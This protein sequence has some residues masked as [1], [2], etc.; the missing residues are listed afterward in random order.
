M[1]AVVFVAAFPKPS[2]SV[3][4]N[5]FVAWEFA[6]PANGVELIA[7]CVPVPAVMVSCW[8]PEVSPVAAAVIVGVPE[9]VSP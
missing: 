5:A 1:V 6:A 8:V 4:V 3:T 7:K 2:S 9:A